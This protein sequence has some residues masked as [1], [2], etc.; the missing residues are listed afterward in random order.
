MPFQ[1]LK[2]LTRDTVHHMSQ[3]TLYN[4]SMHLL[5]IFV[6][7]AWYSLSNHCWHLAQSILILAG[8]WSTYTQ[9]IQ[10]WGVVHN[11]NKLEQVNVFDIETSHLKH[12]VSSVMKKK[13]TAKNAFTTKICHTYSSKPYCKLHCTQ[14]LR[15]LRE[16]YKVQ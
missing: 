4:K 13:I 16:K 5:C 6:S 8:K 3:T 11:G 2:L 15:S 9:W 12:T 1:R 7:S 10:A 14:Q